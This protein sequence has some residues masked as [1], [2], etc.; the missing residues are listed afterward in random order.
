MRTEPG[1]DRLAAL[2]AAVGIVVVILIAAPAIPQG[3]DA[4]ARLLGVLDP[5]RQASRPASDATGLLAAVSA[6][7]ATSV[8]LVLQRKPI[9]AESSPR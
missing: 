5:Y 9:C 2:V 4:A 1:F 8:L 3:W 7:L 6:A